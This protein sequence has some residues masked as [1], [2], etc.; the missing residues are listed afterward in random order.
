MAREGLRSK[1]SSIAGSLKLTTKG[2]EV[3]KFVGFAIPVGAILISFGVAFFVVWPKYNEVMRLKETN[4]QNTE[5]AQKLDVKATELSALDAGKLTEQVAGAEQLLPSDKGVFTMLRQIENT[6]GSSGVLISNLSIAPGAVGKSGGK[7]GAAAPNTAAPALPAKDNVDPPDVSKISV[8]LSLTSDYKGL[9]SFLSGLSALPRVSAVKDL[10]V[11]SQGGTG[12][13]SSSFTIDA[14]WQ[15]IPSEL[16][17]IESPITKITSD[18][19]A[20]LAGVSN[21]SVQSTIPQV[22]LGR[23]DLFAPF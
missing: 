18:E 7:E 3:S 15:V 14:Y 22:P 21:S 8:K 5:L 13:V 23:T 12:Q 4:R 1:M 20:M 6:A 17:S 10:S 16:P 9:L 19:E 11:G 2:A